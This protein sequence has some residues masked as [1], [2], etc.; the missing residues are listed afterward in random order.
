MAEQQFTTEELKSEEWRAVVEYEGLYSV[1][2]LGRVRSERYHGSS[3]PGRLVRQLQTKKGY[4]RVELNNRGKARKFFVHRLVLEAFMG[5]C[6]EGFECN[7]KSGANGNNRLKNLEWVPRAENVRHRVINNLQPQGEEHANAKLTN[8]AVKAIRDSE[9]RVSIL[10][11]RYGVDPTLI[12]MVRS[13]KIW[14]HI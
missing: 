3:Y 13:R 10:A 9:E 2:S 14:K 8:A 5:S 12:R 7:H 11:S 1:S 6:P 4:W